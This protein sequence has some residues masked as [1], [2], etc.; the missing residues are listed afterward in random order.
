MNLSDASGIWMYTY[1]Y[2]KNTQILRA[3]VSFG[4]I[5][6]FQI[7]NGSVYPF[8]IFNVIIMYVIIHAVLCIT[9]C[10]QLQIKQWEKS[11]TWYT[12]IYYYLRL[13]SI[14]WIGIKAAATFGRRWT[15]CHNLWLIRIKLV[16]T[17]CSY[18]QPL[19]EQNR[20]AIHLLFLKSQ[21]ICSCCKWNRNS[22]ENRSLLRSSEG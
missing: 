3:T 17:M 14:R 9:A 15:F 22:T 16:P 21:S 10:I 1:E 13:K 12:R 11:K 6:V 7:T 18:T 20:F 19:V 5:P 8:I 4:L 2:Y